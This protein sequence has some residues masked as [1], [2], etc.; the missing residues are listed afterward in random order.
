MSRRRLLK[1]K[2]ERMSDDSSSLPRPVSPLSSALP[3]GPPPADFQDHCLYAPEAWFVEHID[4]VDAERV[5]VRSDTT[6]MGA[7]VAAQVVRRGH[8]KHVP[9]AV[10]VQLTGTLGSL[11]AVYGLGLRGYVGFGTNIRSARFPGLG[12]IGPPMWAE[13][14]CNRVR[15]LRGRVFTDYVFEYWQTAN[16]E[17]DGE[18]TV[19]YTSEQSA[20]WMPGDLAESAT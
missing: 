1:D 4:H 8:P 15:R 14:R 3:P 17:E 12:R 9:G 5:R 16:D 7:F 10:M 18:R 19:I 2:S 13:G 11:H 6:K 20:I